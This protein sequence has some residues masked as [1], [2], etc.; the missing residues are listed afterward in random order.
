MSGETETYMIIF[1][2]SGNDNFRNVLVKQAKSRDHARF[3]AYLHFFPPT[4]MT[5]HPEKEEVYAHT[6]GF[7]RSGPFL[8][9]NYCDAS[10]YVEPYWS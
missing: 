7:E 10:F 6:S 8:I 1:R 9:H 4:D 5:S 2:I 3:A